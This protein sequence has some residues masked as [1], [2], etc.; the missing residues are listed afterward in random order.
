MSTT[1]IIIL[2]VLLWVAVM[3]G[4]F[5]VA[6]RLSKRWEDSDEAPPP[7]NFVKVEPAQWSEK[8]IATFR[9]TPPHGFPLAYGVD[10]VI[11]A[12]NQMFPGTLTVCVHN[13][14]ARPYFNYPSR[15]A[16]DNDW[17]VEPNEMHY[18]PYIKTA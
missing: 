15:A 12:T 5:V 7:P 8:I 13:G 3:A 10:Y 1:T 6:Q 11:S 9:G 14:P 16:F 2:A 17:H 18:L 4:V